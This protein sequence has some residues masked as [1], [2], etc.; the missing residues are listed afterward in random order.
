M[1]VVQQT[2]TI[3]VSDPGLLTISMRISGDHI[4]SCFLVSP[5]LYWQHVSLPRASSF[6]SLH[7]WHTKRV[8]TDE[9]DLHDMHQV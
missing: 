6:R 1:R 7:K 3:V 5:S 2:D 4:N 8:E 9:R